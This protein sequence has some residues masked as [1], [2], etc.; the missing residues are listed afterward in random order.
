MRLHLKSAPVG[1]LKCNFESVT[2]FTLRQRLKRR[3]LIARLQA[4][5]DAKQRL[6]E[7]IS[8]CTRRGLSAT[9]SQA[10]WIAY[11]GSAR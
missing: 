3:Q 5:G 6:Q 10:A 2:L 7:C 9:A 8:R 4:Q 1:L 11:L